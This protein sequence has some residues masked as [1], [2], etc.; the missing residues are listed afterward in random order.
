M[1]PSFS[2]NRYT[3]F[4]Y[5][6]DFNDGIFP[7]DFAEHNNLTFG[8]L[9]F[10]NNKYV[11]MKEEIEVCVPDQSIY[12]RYKDLFIEDGVQNKTV[13]TTL[14][15]G[16]HFRLSLDGKNLWG[17][18]EK[19]IMPE[20]KGRAFFLHDYNLNNITNSIEI[21]QYIIKKYRLSDYKTSLG[22]KF[23]IIC[24]TPEAFED[25]SN[26]TFA[27]A[28]Y[29]LQYNGLLSDEEFVYFVNKVSL[30]QAKK[31][32]YNP[33]PNASTK[34]DF[35]ED[36]LVKIFKQVLFLYMNG[37]EFSLIC[38][39]DFSIPYEI[40]KIFSLLSSYCKTKRE[41]YNTTSFYYY[42][43]QFKRRKL[44]KKTLISIEEARELFYFVR[45]N[46]PEL[47][48]LFYEAGAVEYKGGELVVI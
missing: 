41:K 37:K 24:S 29:R 27:T 1:A 13:W 19:Q 25:W 36:D 45:E 42:I 9:A 33:F 28:N 15:N 32:Y 47:F 30:E 38:N 35:S 31:I 4:Y 12:L 22:V 43:T 5:R 7:S 44:Y 40:K 14:Y 8:G 2:P 46:Y 18:Y 48:R 34:N 11:P 26:F 17:E 21:L 16:V 20:T 23:P 3:H 39:D 6:K 10:S